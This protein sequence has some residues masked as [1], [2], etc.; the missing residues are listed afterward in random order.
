MRPTLSDP[1]CVRKTGEIWINDLYSPPMETFSVVTFGCK[2]NQYESQA[3]KERLERRGMKEAPAGGA[4]D[5][6]VVNSCT[7]TKTAVHEAKRIVRRLARR[8]PFSKITVTGCA[9][10]SHRDEFLQMDG[11]RHKRIRL[12]A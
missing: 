5:L 2:V 9:A 8:N 4:A 7:V 3:I 1:V 6:F 12:I 11:V 10:D